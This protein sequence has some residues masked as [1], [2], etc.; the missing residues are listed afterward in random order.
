MIAK[1]SVMIACYFLYNFFVL[2]GVHTSQ[3]GWAA[4]QALAWLLS[5]LNLLHGVSVSQILYLLLS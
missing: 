1:L 2:R 5:S 4:L 3:P